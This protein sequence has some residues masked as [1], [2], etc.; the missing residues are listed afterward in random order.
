MRVLLIGSTFPR[1][2][3]DDQVPWLREICCRVRDAG[4]EIEVLAPS[5]KGLKSHTIDGITVHRFRY[6][7]TAWETLTGEEGAPNK[8]RRNPF[9]FF[10]MVS[11]MWC[12]F[13]ALIKLLCGSKKY[14]LIE[15]HWPCPHSYLALPAIVA[16]IPAIYHYHSAEPKLAAQSWITNVMF[17]FSLGWAKAHV[18]NSSYTTGLIKKLN[19]KLKVEVIAYGSPLKF[20]A[21]APK[22]CSRRKLLFVGRHVERKGI[23]YLIS[24]LKLLPSEYTLT[25]IGD[26][27]QTEALKKQAEELIKQGRV[28]FT[29]RIPNEEIARAYQK[30]DIFVCPSIIDSKGDTEGLGVVLIEAFAAGLPIAAS[31]VG[32][33]PDIII[34]GQTGLL[35]EEKNSEALAK[36]IQKIGDDETLAQKLIAGARAHAQKYFSWESVTQQTLKIYQSVSGKL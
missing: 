9:L 21:D 29:G 22:T 15:V 27:D 16:G 33:I 12:G 10:V 20:S 26:G 2:E 28:V 8:L 30:H 17:K 31:N 19:P 34:D 32:G 25:I 6:A 24:A 18:A 7:P 4:V 11:Y 14:D 35:V 3:T 5:F 13:W 23:P 1:H 36:A